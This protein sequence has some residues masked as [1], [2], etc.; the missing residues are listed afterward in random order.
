MGGEILEETSLTGALTNDYVF[1][2]GSRVARMDTTGDIY[3]YFEDHLG[4]SRKMRKIAPGANTSTLVYDAD[5]YPYGRQHLITNS[6]GPIY[7]FN[8]KMRD[9]ESGL[10]D[11]GARYYVPQWSGCRR[12][13]DKFVVFAHASRGCLYLPSFE[14]RF[15]IL[16]LASL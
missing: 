10:D 6:T 3:A 9:T 11:F 5:F 8:G 4:S 15:S 16:V 13:A 7:K 14:F 12:D 2:A 1:F